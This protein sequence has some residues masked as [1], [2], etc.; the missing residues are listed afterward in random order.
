VSTPWPL[1]AAPAH[2]NV[3]AAQCTLDMLCHS[4]SMGLRRTVTQLVFTCLLNDSMVTSHL[5]MHNLYHPPLLHHQPPIHRDFLRS[6][7]F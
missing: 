2:L 3:G 7:E 4:V 5:Y 6:K 1:G